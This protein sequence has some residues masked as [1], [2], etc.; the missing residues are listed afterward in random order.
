MSREPARGG[1]ADTEGMEE[2]GVPAF[3]LRQEGRIPEAI[4]TYRQALALAPAMNG[5]RMDLAQT[6]IERDPQIVEIAK[7]RVEELRSMASAE[8]STDMLAVTTASDESA[9]NPGDAES[10]DS[11]APKARSRKG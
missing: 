8:L 4:L 10:T 6:L 11:E 7:A 2:A 1:G 9:G 3:S 5:T